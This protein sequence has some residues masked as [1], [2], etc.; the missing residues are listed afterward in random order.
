MWESPSQI[1]GDDFGRGQ[2]GAFLQGIV[3]EP[4]DIE[5]H[6]VVLDQ[7]FVGEGLEPLALVAVQCGSGV[8]PL[9][10]SPK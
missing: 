4:E 1:L 7:L 9:P 5:V 6:L 3:F 10:L 2:V 8:P